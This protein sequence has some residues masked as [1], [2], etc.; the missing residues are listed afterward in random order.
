MEMIKKNELYEKIK[1]SLKKYID[2]NYV[3]IKKY[4]MENGVREKAGRISGTFL[5]SKINKTSSSRN[6]T[7]D[8]LENRVNHISDTWQESLFNFI[9]IKGFNEVEVYKTAGIDRKLFSKIRSNKDYKPKKNTVLAFAI[10]LNLNIDETRDFL[11]R[12]GYALSPSSKFDLII[13][14]F[15]ENEIYDFYTINLALTDYKE[16]VIIE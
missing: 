7:K 1:K 11:K 6:H 4:T 5:S 9:D 2:D 8:S 10:A 12:A 3:D 13:E 16:S 15:I 14:Y